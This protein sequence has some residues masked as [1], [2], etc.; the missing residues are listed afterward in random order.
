MSFD[1]SAAGSPEEV[2]GQLMSAN[3]RGDVLG[4][5][6]RQLILRNLNFPKVIGPQDRYVFTVQVAGSSND[7]ALMSLHVET[8]AYWVPYVPAST[9]E[10]A[11]QH[12]KDGLRIPEGD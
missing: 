11:R 10:K 6:I 9:A 12:V 5:E 4:E 1:F 7:H 8:H 2:I 3:V